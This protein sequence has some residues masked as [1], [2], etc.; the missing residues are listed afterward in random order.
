MGQENMPRMSFFVFAAVVFATAQATITWDGVR[1]KASVG[2]LELVNNQTLGAKEPYWNG[3]QG[4]L[5]NLEGLS[6][7][8]VHITG[9]KSAILTANA[10]CPMA[11]L[12][13][14]SSAKEIA[15]A[16]RQCAWGANTDAGFPTIGNTDAVLA[17]YNS[18]MARQYASVMGQKGVGDRVRSPLRF[19]KTEVRDA[20]VDAAGN[21]Y[22][23]G[24]TTGNFSNA[25]EK[26]TPGVGND[27][28]SDPPATDMFIAKYNASGSQ[29]WVKQLG[30]RSNATQTNSKVLT[31]GNSIFFLDGN[32]FVTGTTYGTTGLNE[33]D[34]ASGKTIDTGKNSNGDVFIAKYA[35]DGNLISVKHLPNI[36]EGKSEVFSITGRGANI[37]ISGITAYNMSVE[38]R[39]S[40][41]RDPRL[42]PAGTMVGFIASYAASNLALQWTKMLDFTSNTTRVGTDGTTSYPISADGDT[43]YKVKIALSTK[44]IIVAGD[45]KGEYLDKKASSISPM[46]GTEV[47]VMSAHSF[48][49]GQVVWSTIFQPTPYTPQFSNGTRMTTIRPLQPLLRVHDLALDSKD[50][51]Y[52]T[53]HWHVMWTDGS[54][55][56]EI[57]VGWFAKFNTSTS[58][59]QLVSQQH[60]GGNSTGLITNAIGLMR[61][62]G[63]S[64]VLDG[65]YTAY[66]AGFEIG[67]GGGKRRAPTRYK[68]AR[69]Y[70]FSTDYRAPPAAPTA[71]PTT[72]VTKAPSKTAPITVTMDATF[73]DINASSYSNSSFKPIAELGVG[74]ALRIVVDTNDDWKP[75]C[76]V[77]SSAN[78]RS[79]TVT[80]VATI[81]TAHVAAANAAAVSITKSS[82]H[83]HILAA[84][85]ANV[86]KG[87]TSVDIPTISAV[88]TPVC[89][90]GSCTASTTSGASQ[91]AVGVTALVAVA[92]ALKH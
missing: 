42:V 47:A 41:A 90:S 70:K 17:N 89:S 29:L 43:I 39:G 30:L 57:Q 92:L 24:K 55:R 79:A 5:A 36:V 46:V 6:P 3:D 37:Y 56:K 44:H 85:T 50:N 91:V 31:V 71:A 10:E 83:S 48:S 38:G 59:A 84:N 69:L 87:G 26:L 25:R 61:A 21:V 63:T 76:A 78:R 35:T 86:R 32:A 81:P 1:T 45:S 88:G 60:F 75:G 13:S 51:I 34:K 52:L 14:T 18:A 54:L 16:Y 12:D 62:S 7:P 68:E 65:D 73:S 77:T 67:V 11:D 8:T 82:L 64:I 58:G 53:G 49:N 15:G 40:D 33:I 72:E 9:N 22:M 74:I 4:Q 23:V 66:V 20:A 2:Q 19:I 27:G 28:E 80:F